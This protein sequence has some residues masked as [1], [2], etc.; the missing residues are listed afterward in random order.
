[1]SNGIQAVQRYPDVWLRLIGSV[2][3]SHLVETV[4]REE[5]LA[6]QWVSINYWIALVSGSAI[7]FLVWT[8]ISRMT[9][10]LDQRYDWLEN[11]IQRIGLQAVFGVLLTGVLLLVLT[12]IQVKLLWN[13][14]IIQNGFHLTEF[15]LILLI[16]VLVN[17]MYFTW[18]L[19]NRLRQA[20]SQ[21][22][23]TLPEPAPANSYLNVLVVNTGKMQ[24]PV[25]VSSILYI[26][27]QG[28]YTLIK[29]TDREFL[30]TTPLDDLEAS[31]DPAHFFRANRQVIIAYSTCKG[32]RSLDYGKLEVQTE[33]VMNEPLVVSQKKARAFR[34]WM[35]K[36]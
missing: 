6:E 33:P 1:M 22:I 31:L 9:A 23:T 18:Y 7:A 3:F 12:W 25:P 2:V 11:T 8:I 5:S 20:E 35:A 16:L 10:W 27:R 30:E 21:P 17:G 15:P 36:R 4:G 26:I 34:E 32:I 14:D 29:T 24:V 19:Y 13:Q 28:D